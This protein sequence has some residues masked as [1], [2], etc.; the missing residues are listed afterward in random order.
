[1]HIFIPIKHNSQRVP[2]KNFRLIGDKPLWRHTV[3]KL[4]KTYTVC[5]DTDSDDII[6][7]CKNLD[8][9]LA[10]QRK[11]S[12]CGDKISVIKLLKYFKN[13]FNVTDNICQVHVTSPFLDI[14]HIEVAENKLK[15]GYDS[16]FGVNVMQQR[17]WRKESYGYCPVNHNPMKLEQTQ[18]LPKYY[19][20][21][22]YL[23]AFKPEVLDNNNRIGNNPYLLEIDFPYNLDIDTEE[24]W[25]TINHLSKIQI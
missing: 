16:V 18:D 23:Y 12:L 3:E 24:D 2:S 4:N 5:I 11:D 8:N 17:L 6:R 25:D 19:C 10:Y 9:V 13:K 14:K 15:E 21:N 22:S 1:M 20:E 7:E